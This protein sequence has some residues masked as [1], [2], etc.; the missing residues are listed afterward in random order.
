MSDDPKHKA[1]E[2]IQNLKKE[3]RANEILRKGVGPLVLLIAAVQLWSIYSG[4]EEN[5]KESERY[6]V[7]ADQAKA[8]AAEAQKTTEC[9]AKYNKALVENLRLRS[10]ASVR[11]N[12]ATQKLI[13]TFADLPD[14]SASDVATT[15]RAF[16]IFKKEIVSAERARA[17][18]PLLPYP[19]C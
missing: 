16:K 17:R 3:S 6:K 13:L 9:Q 18:Y 1:N 11:V 4:A 8:L 2:E 12:S 5:R 7:I 14:P 19:D 10:E 15:L